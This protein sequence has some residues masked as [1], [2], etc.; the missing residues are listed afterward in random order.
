MMSRPEMALGL[1]WI[2]ICQA[3]DI[4]PPALA[5]A[6]SG[7]IARGRHGERA[8]LRWRRAVSLIC[9]GL[10]IR[11]TVSASGAALL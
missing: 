6:G 11:M 3:D 9:A 8:G 7:W 5:E 4:E 2:N 10:A 1:I